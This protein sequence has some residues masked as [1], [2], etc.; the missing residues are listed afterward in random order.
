MSSLLKK[1][2]IDFDMECVIVYWKSLFMI[3]AEF[4]KQKK[5]D[6]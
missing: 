2:T 4:R 3:Y 6:L 1:M 5:Q